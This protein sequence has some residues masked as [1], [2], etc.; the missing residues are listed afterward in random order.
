MADALSS[1][2]MLLAAIALIYSAW[3]GSIDTEATRTYSGQAETKADEKA[4]TRKVLNRRARPMMVVSSLVFVVF[5][6][7]DWSI[8]YHSGACAV[9]SVTDCHYD[10]VA[11]IFLLTQLVV[12]GL[13]LHLRGRVSELKKQIAS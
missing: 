5:L 12:I 6:N 11:A 9:G 2:S 4:Q 8:L 1:A 3:S 10:D 13:A 7:R